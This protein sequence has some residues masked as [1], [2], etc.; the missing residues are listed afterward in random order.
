[1]RW[2]AAPRG[3]VLGAQ[4]TAAGGR[5]VKKQ[6][7]AAATAA[8]T[9][10]L[11][12]AGCASTQH[13]AASSRAS[14]TPAGATEASTAARAS[15]NPACKAKLSAWRPEGERFERTL[16]HN[17]GA[18][19]SDLQSIITQMEE[20]AQPG[21]GAALTGSG[22]LASAA[23]QMLDHHLPPSCVPHMRAGLI[24]SMLDFEKQA[25]DVTNA[26]LAL[27][28]WNAQGAERLLKA[29]SHDITAGATGIR[30]ATADSDSYQG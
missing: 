30:Q 29:A 12:A 28:D 5:A 16:L 15:S 3:A 25:A 23:K 26:S 9:A 2:A 6:I 1:M 24:R 27:S 4:S 18:A 13:P 22:T 14:P 20:G 17:A 8:A 7:T 11:L 19:E 10:T 21:V